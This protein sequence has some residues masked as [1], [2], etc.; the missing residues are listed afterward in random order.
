LWDA[1]ADSLAEPHATLG[2]VMS[3]YDYDFAGAER[4]LKRAI[5]LNPKYATAHQWYGEV[6]TYVGRLDEASAEFQRSLEIE[7]LSLPLNWDYARFLYMSRRLTTRSR[8]I[9]RRLT[10][11]PVLRER[12]ERSR[13]SIA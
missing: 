9:K 10:W 2:Y 3:Q 6:L 1:L 12:T 5:E 8:S 4:E 13:S 11:I 7:P